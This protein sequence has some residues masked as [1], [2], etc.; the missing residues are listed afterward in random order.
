MKI[1]IFRVR[2]FDASLVEAFGRLLPQ[3]SS[4]A[5]MP[6]VEHV[7]KILSSEGTYLLAAADEAGRI[8]GM[9]TLALVDIPTGR[10]AW[11]EDVVVDEACRGYGVGAKLVERAIAIAEEAGAKVVCLTSN[12]SREAAHA[13]YRKSGFESYDTVVFRKPL[14]VLKK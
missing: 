14:P 12:P 9:L 2:E 13:L 8:V 3:L 7:G 1:D 10:K 11:I 4:R 6:S 5:V